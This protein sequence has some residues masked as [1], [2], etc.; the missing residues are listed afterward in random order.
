[1]FFRRRFIATLFIL[2]PATSFAQTAGD[3][4]RM[5]SLTATA[6]A[7]PGTKNFTPRPGWPPHG[8]Q[9]ADAASCLSSGNKVCNNGGCYDR[10]VT[11]CQ[12]YPRS[13]AACEN[14][15][16]C[17]AGGCCGPNQECSASGLCYPTGRP[18]GPFTKP[19]PSGALPVAVLRPAPVPLRAPAAPAAPAPVSAPPP[20][21]VPLRAPT[22]PS[23]PAPIPA[24]PRPASVPASSPP[25]ANWI[26]CAACSWPDAN[27]AAHSTVACSGEQKTEAIAESEALQAARAQGG[28]NCRAAAVNS[29]CIYVS[30]GQSPQGTG[31]GGGVSP[32]AALASCQTEVP[33]GTCQTPIGG[34]VSPAAVPPRPPPQPSGPSNVGPGCGS[35]CS[36]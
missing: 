21:P 33:G 24:P 11:C 7:A 32:A 10:T 27:G 4:I 13:V 28:Q 25:E 20:A 26:A 17:C 9:L 3:S 18:D 30:S 1:M 35:G 12:A 31:T 6:P 15:E 29:G 22:A 34:C 5:A 14:G 23:T 36:N 16:A 8:L 2:L 19:N